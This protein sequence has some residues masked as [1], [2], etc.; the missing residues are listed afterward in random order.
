MLGPGADTGIPK[1]G[2]EVLAPPNR[3]LGRATPASTFFSDSCAVDEG[4]RLNGSELVE[5]GC[6]DDVNVGGVE[7]KLN[8][9]RDGP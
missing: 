8:G 2:N 5:D 6:E 4:V 1:P 7:P 9:T 3:G